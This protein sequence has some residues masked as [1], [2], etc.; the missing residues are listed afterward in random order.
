MQDLSPVATLWPARDVL[1]EQNAVPFARS[2]QQ[3]LRMAA[4]LM[5]CAYIAGV[6]WWC[7][8]KNTKT[9][10]DNICIPTLH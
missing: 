10:S 5:Y 1:V 9:P 3:L 8:L 2:G 4:R 6:S 7:C